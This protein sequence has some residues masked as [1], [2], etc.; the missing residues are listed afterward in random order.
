MLLD[1]DDKPYYVNVK[2][3][4][5]EGEFLRAQYKDIIPGYYSDKRCWNSILADGEVPDELVRAL[6]DKS[7]FLVLHGFSGKKQREIVGLSA[8]G[9][10]CTSCDFFGKGCVGCTE[11]GGHTFAGSPCA[12][13]ACAVNKKR[14]PS[15]ADCEAPACPIWQKTRDPSFSDEAFAENLRERAENLRH[16]G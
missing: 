13:Y 16:F 9:T 6:L 8:C 11:A 15:C 7:Y 5:A 14:R 3:D 12:I 10:D 1:D 2:L 4:P